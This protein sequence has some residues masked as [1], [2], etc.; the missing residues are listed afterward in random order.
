[1]KCPPKRADF[2]ISARTLKRSEAEC[3][4]S[5][6]EQHLLEKMSADSR[7]PDPF[8]ENEDSIVDFIVTLASVIQDSREVFEQDQ[9]KESKEQVWSGVLESIRS[10]SSL[11][12]ID[13]DL[14]EEGSCGRLVGKMP[15]LQEVR[16]AV[17]TGLLDADDF[18]VLV[19][20]FEP[21]IEMCRPENISILLAKRRE[22]DSQRPLSNA[23]SRD[24]LCESSLGEAPR[25][26]KR[27]LFPPLVIATLETI[28]KHAGNSNIRLAMFQI[29]RGIAG[30]LINC[31]WKD[32]NALT[33]LSRPALSDLIV[34]LADCGSE[35]EAPEASESGLSKK[36][37][38]CP[39]CHIR[40]VVLSSILSKL[41]E[42]LNT[43]RMNGSACGSV[44][45]HMVDNFALCFSISNHIIHQYHPS[46]YL[47]QVNSGSE[48]GYK[49]WWILKS[50][51]FSLIHHTRHA[52]GCKDAA[53]L[54]QLSLYFFNQLD[55]SHL[56]LKK[57]STKGHLYKNL[58][59]NKQIHN[60]CFFNEYLYG[61][62]EVD[63]PASLQSILFN[64]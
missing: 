3:T 7:G 50:E 63:L 25:P 39:S 18:E 21:I 5:P 4:E 61:N 53:V 44:Q 20:T 45:I 62:A 42:T 57:V 49:G 10:R 15:D 29:C 19:R 59:L 34:S 12:A 6:S 11:C 32:D 40:E 1:M 28:A 24:P 48:R 8:Q 31:G 46:C 30:S 55:S 52:P 36:K 35:G 23:A 47:E 38:P 14:S 64:S 58:S 54:S 60:G 37:L 16:E 41:L 13:C 2:F 26:E 51:L 22:G 27:S 56:T 43:L 33:W 9:K 17:S